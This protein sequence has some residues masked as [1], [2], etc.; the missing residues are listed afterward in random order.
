M[1][2]IGFSA[3]STCWLVL[4]KNCHWLGVP[5]SQNG[6]L[7]ASTTSSE[8]S[9]WPHTRVSLPKTD[10]GEN[11]EGVLGWGVGCPGVPFLQTTLECV[12]GEQK[13]SCSVP[14]RVK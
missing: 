2:M 9:A 6:A 1:W 14:R 3:A 4:C 7:P 10:A 13:S 8:T 12:M 5:T 11:M